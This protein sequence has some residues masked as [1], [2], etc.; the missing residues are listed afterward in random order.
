MKRQ[1]GVFQF[2]SSP[3]ITLAILS[4]SGMIVMFAETMILPAVPDFIEDFDISYENSSW[5]LAIFLVMGAVMTPIAGKFADAYGK[6]KMLLIILGAY[7]IGILL[8]ALSTNFPFMV[9]ARAVQGIGISIFPIAFSI[10]RDK[11]VPE[12]LALAQGIFSSM[13]SAGAVIGLVVGASIIE[14]FGWRATFLLILPIVI[15]LFALIKKYITLKE[16]E[17]VYTVSDKSSEFCC[18]FIHV[19]KDILLSEN[20]VQKNHKFETHHLNDNKTKKSLLH[21]ID[22]KGALALSVM[23]VSFLILLQFIEKSGSSS[24]Y[25][26]QIVI[27]SSIS[28]I[29][30]IFFV[31]VEKRT[32]LPLIDF[33]LLT[34]KVILSANIVNMVVGITALMVVYQ[35]IPIF[36]RSPPPVGFAGDALTVA[37]IQLP[38]MIVSLIFSI[39][40]GFIISKIGNLRPTIIGTLVTTIGF[41]IL[42]LIH[43]TEIAIMLILVIVAIGLA[44]MQV[45]SMNVVLMST[46]KQ[47]SGTSLG[48]TLL[49]YLIGASVGPVI[50][51]IYMETYQVILQA[52]DLVSSFPSNEAYNLILVTATLISAGSIAF[53]LFMYKSVESQKGVVIS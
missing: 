49:I 42:F 9:V 25:I 13:L 34:N 17:N 21:S 44:F 11:F 32:L 8:G 29:S 22:L 3:W 30:L 48:M 19:R 52:G 40:S 31:I 4:S 14:S 7:G 15:I 37:H 16:D 10:I 45:G 35:S 43:S 2:L 38:Y 20:R 41:L 5:I 39:A 23:V 6:K 28:V 26:I 1:I 12:K 50:A 46:P 36:V 53:A 18:R 27:F 33:K 24:T 47:F 51:G